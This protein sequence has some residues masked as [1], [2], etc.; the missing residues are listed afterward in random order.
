MHRET[1]FAGHEARSARHG[2]ALQHAIE[3]KPEI[4][5]QP[6]RRMLLHDEGKL[7]GLRLPAR[8]RRVRWCCG[9]RAW[10]G[11]YRGPPRRILARFTQ[12]SGAGR[13][14]CLARA[15]RTPAFASG[16]SALHLARLGTLGSGLGLRLGGSLG[17][18]LARGAAAEP[19]PRCSSPGTALPGRAVRFAAA[20]L[21]AR[22]GSFLPGR[23]L[24]ADP[25]S[26]WTLRRSASIRLTTLLGF[27][28][29]CGSSA[30]LPLL[31]R[32]SQVR[33]ARSRSGPRMP[34]GRI[35]LPCAR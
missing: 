19:P 11:R 15:F 12:A 21:D 8:A 28:A 16:R 7:R 17:G 30:C 29:A 6:C 34:S 2:P 24:S 5:M 31:L 22:A 23:S 25:F 3:F 18:G 27:G 10:R 33:S 26:A 1:L 4:V 14:R 9:N 13:R 35:A 32:P 20:R